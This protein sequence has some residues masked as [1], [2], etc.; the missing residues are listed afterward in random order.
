MN[1]AFPE[2]FLQERLGSFSWSPG[3]SNGGRSLKSFCDVTLQ[4]VIGRVVQSDKKN[5]KAGTGS[6]AP[7][8]DEAEDL[9][10]RLRSLRVVDGDIPEINYSSLRFPIMFRADLPAQKFP[11]RFPNDPGYVVPLYVAAT[12]GLALKDVDFLLGGSALEILANRS[13]DDDCSYLLQRVKNVIVMAKS[14]DYVQNYADVGFQFERLVTGAGIGDLHGKIKHENLQVMRIGT[15][16][17]LFSADVDA[18]DASGNVVEVKSG[19]PRYFG[20]KVMFQMLSSGAQSLV[21]ADKRGSSLN[22]IIKRTI[23]E[24]MEEHAQSQR[25]RMQR[26]IVSALTA[27]KEKSAEISESFPCR[28]VLTGAEGILLQPRPESE[29]LLPKVEVVDALLLTAASKSVASQKSSSSVTPAAPP[30]AAVSSLSMLPSIIQ[31]KLPIIGASVVREE[32]PLSSVLKKN[33]P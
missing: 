25:L 16:K 1:S 15:M 30:G 10:E 4:D 11:N 33:P 14:K 24:L 6:S 13:I 31:A 23:D 21:F 26:N 8:V 32:K 18:I 27:I 19:N 22:G 29:S 17:V 5:I 3:P 12:R 7:A 28:L 9:V 20:S 2:F